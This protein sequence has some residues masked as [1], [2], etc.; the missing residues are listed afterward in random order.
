MFEASAV[1]LDALLRMNL[2]IKLADEIDVDVLDFGLRE[3]V[4]LRLP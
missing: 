1:S 3:S 4:S 2:A